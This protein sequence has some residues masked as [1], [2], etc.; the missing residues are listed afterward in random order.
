[1][2]GPAEKAYLQ[3]LPEDRKEALR[4]LTKMFNLDWNYAV[5]TIGKEANEVRQKL[6]DEYEVLYHKQ[7]LPVNVLSVTEKRDLDKKQLVN[8]KQLTRE[9]KADNKLKIANKIKEESKKQV[10]ISF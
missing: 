5:V 10:S 9:F 8:E 2:L 7:N 6:L 4:L 1:M 3:S